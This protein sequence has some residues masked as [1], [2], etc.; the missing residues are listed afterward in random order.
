[1]SLLAPLFLAGLL[2]IAVP[3]WLHRLQTESSDRKPFSSAMLLEKSD[4]RIHVRK[5]LKYFTL[6]A[7]RVL[8]LALLAF[9]F[10]R[11]LWTN[12]EALPGPAP[13]GT[14]VVLIDTSASMSRDGVFERALE[15]ARSAIDAAPRGALVQ[16]F[17]ASA[18]LREVTPLAADR[19]AHRAALDGLEADPTRLDL[20]RA[21]AAID[22]LAETLPAPVTLH[23]VSDLQE[24][25]LPVRFS[26][27]VA[28]N[29]VALQTHDAAGAGTGNWSIDSIRVAGDAADVVVTGT[30][31]GDDA[32]NVSLTLNGVIVGEQQT[33]GSGT[34]SLR[35]DGLA[36]E[37]GDNRLQAEIAAADE[38]LIDNTYY[39]VLRNEPPAPIP[40]L[41]I[42]RGGLPV[43]YL[44]AALHSDPDG[45]YRVEPA[46]VGDFDTRTLSRFRWVIV[47][48]IGVV[49]PMLE[50]ALAEFVEAGGGLLAFAGERSATLT[51]VPVLGNEISG[52]SIGAPDSGFL[53][54]G[55]VDAG[56]PLLAG[57]EGWYAV[58]VAQ[59]VPV[60]AATADQV[61]ARLDNGEPFLIERRIGQG[62]VLLVAGGLENRWNDLPI[63]PVFVS[64]MIEAARYLSATEQ[65]Q[66]AF[67]AGESL[68][69]AQAGAASGQVVD[70][71]GRSVLS[72]ADTT[73]AQR[74]SL[75]KTGFYEVYTRD[76]EYLVAV[77]TDPRESMLAAIEAET[78]QRWESAMEG[79]GAP[80]ESAVPAQQAAPYELWHVLLFIL[81]LVLI[82]ESVLANAYLTPRTSGGTT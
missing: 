17:A 73:R 81:A 19:A 54:I 80:R 74:I 20:G 11:P 27:L 10:A 40:L 21:M 49:D 70:P 41:T 42:N 44:S 14:H 16:V 71:D 31:V 6:L 61:L 13:D 50:A 67:A 7:L 63:R 47:D 39:Q 36:L 77:N 75:R 55:E 34:T 4:Q 53:A 37:P 35:F 22:R 62:R 12:P 72:L 26:D 51:R 33:A 52:A 38:L 1:M 64:F 59:T 8:F 43:T 82:A 30:G 15:L 5:K 9:A 45:A 68:P 65:L 78:L 25:G 66:R 23:V 79:S 29:L 58:N 60:R 46:I 69:L 18:D 3:F 2:A 56:H 76:G 24:S 32:V 28:A 57:T 48:D